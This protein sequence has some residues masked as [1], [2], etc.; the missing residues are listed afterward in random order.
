MIFLAVL[1][2]LPTLT[3]IVCIMYTYV[4]IVNWLMPA[5]VQVQL[6][7]GHNKARLEVTAARSEAQQLA[8]QLQETQQQL[9]SLQQQLADAL[10][11]QQALKSSYLQLEAE[12]GLAAK[13][14]NETR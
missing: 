1:P 13:V 14:Q 2:A 6:L 10:G 3:C 4:C 11:Q 5:E 9:A 7:E 12:P 8:L